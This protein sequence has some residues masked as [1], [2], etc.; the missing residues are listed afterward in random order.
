MLNDLAF[1]KFSKDVYQKFGFMDE[2]ELATLLKKSKTAK[3]EDERI[4]AASQYKSY[5]DSGKKTYDKLS[6]EEQDG[7]V[8]MPSDKLLKTGI[9][10]YG[11]LSGKWVPKEMADDIKVQKAFSDGESLL[12]RLYAWKP[13]QK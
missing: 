4:L 1:H 2:D 6:P 12:G 3:T 10:K 13:F 11:E 7:M 8:Q 9:N 5:K